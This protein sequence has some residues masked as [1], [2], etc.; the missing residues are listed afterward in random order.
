MEK[1]GRI[2]TNMHVNEGPQKGQP[3]LM[4]RPR[5][6]YLWATDEVYLDSIVRSRLRNTGGTSLDKSRE[7]RMK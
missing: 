4:V 6:K 1:D 3:G 2:G 7:K 5:L